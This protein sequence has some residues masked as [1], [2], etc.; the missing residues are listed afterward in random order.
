MPTSSASP[1]TVL[2]RSAAVAALNE[3]RE[4][5]P[6]KIDNASLPAGAP[7][8]YYCISCG[9]LS[10]TKPENWVIGSVKKLCSECQAMKD[11]GWLE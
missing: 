6:N 7:M 4:N 1:K 10:D 3:R 2:G 11:L 9:H 8:Y 5:K